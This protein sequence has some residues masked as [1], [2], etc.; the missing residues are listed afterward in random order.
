MVIPRDAI[1]R[2]IGAYIAPRR[3][4]TSGDPRVD[5]K[6]QIAVTISDG[7]A[8]IRLRRTRL[9]KPTLRKTPNLIRRPRNHAPDTSPYCCSIAYRSPVRSAPRI[10]YRRSGV[11]FRGAARVR[12]HKSRTIAGHQGERSVVYSVRKSGD[13]NRYRRA[14]GWRRIRRRES[15]CISRVSAGAIRRSGQSV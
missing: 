9:G 1:I 7:S 2:S 15:T 10:I 12:N 5:C 6:L 4:T 13:D 11:A 3:R 8:S 14:D